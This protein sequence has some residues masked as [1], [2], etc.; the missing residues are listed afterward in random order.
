MP[1]FGLTDAC[2]W[3][4]RRCRR[5]DALFGL[6][7]GRRR[8]DSQSD[9]GAKKILKRLSFSNI[10]IPSSMSNFPGVLMIAEESTSFT[11]VTHPVEQGGLGFDMKWNM[12]WMNDTLRYFHKDMI[13]RTLPSQ[14]FDFWPAL[15]L[16]GT[17]CSRPVA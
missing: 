4:A 15:R 17:V 12:G 13:F 5:F 11:G 9:M 2:R 7:A 3:L 6:W 10:S 8:M 14:R 16:F 1:Y